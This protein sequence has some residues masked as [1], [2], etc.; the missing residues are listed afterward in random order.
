MAAIWGRL[1][2]TGQ[3][4]SRHEQAAA[5]EEWEEPAVVH[6]AVSATEAEA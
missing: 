3:R 5:E 2:R 1:R 4:R 6:A